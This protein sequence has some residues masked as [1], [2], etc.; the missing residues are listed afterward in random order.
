MQAPPKHCRYLFPGGHEDIKIPAASVPERGDL[1]YLTSQRQ[2]FV[3]TSIEWEIFFT[4]EDNW[5]ILI[6][7]NPVYDTT[8]DLS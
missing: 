5:R 6:Y 3:V 2:E 7:C 1:I 4:L 8:D